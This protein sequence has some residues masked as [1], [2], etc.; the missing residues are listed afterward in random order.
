MNLRLAAAFAVV[1]A[2]AV[3]AIGYAV[4]TRNQGLDRAA[5]EAMVKE[6][7]ATSKPAPQASMAPTA[8]KP[9]ET[10][11]AELSNDQRADIEGTTPSTSSSGRRT[12]RH[13]RRKP[14]SSPT[15]A[16]FSSTRRT[17]SCS[18]IPR[19]T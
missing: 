8:A 3:G 16:S 5:V 1:L 12:T 11:T 10:Q 18:A 9:A 14:R 6:M 13:A 7:I 4:G 17:R 19:A 15:T 2:V